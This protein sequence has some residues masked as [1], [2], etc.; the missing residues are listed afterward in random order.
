M[1]RPN[2]QTSNYGWALWH[3]EQVEMANGTDVAQLHAE[4]ANAHATLALVDS[5]P[6]DG[7]VER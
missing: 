7:T 4:M 6:V 3:L 1:N 5:L 2:N